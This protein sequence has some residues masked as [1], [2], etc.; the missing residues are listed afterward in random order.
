MRA[1]RFASPV[2]LVSRRSQLSGGDIGARGDAL[3]DD[4][5]RGE[6]IFVEAVT[7]PGSGVPGVPLALQMR[8][9]LLRGD[10]SGFDE[11]VRVL[12]FGDKRLVTRWERWIESAQQRCL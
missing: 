11:R 7:E 9:F 8:K 3:R 10:G 12:E 5:C 6:A 2:N 4:V 1:S